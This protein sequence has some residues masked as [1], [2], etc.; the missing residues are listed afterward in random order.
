MKKIYTLLLLMIFS[1]GVKAQIIDYF[2]FE[3][4]MGDTIWI[5]FANGADTIVETLSVVANVFPAEPNESDSVLQFIVKDDSDPWVG[6]YTDQVEPMIFTEE[7]HT[8]SMMVYKEKISPL[9]MKFE[10]SLT[11]GEDVSTTVEN[12]LVDEWE[13]LNF[14]MSAAIPHYYG[15]LTIFP[16]FPEARDGGTTVLI[17]NIGSYELNTAVF[18][19]ENGLSLEIYPNP[20]LDKMAVQY[21]E[22]TGISVTDLQGKTIKSITFQKTDSKVVELYDLPSGAYIVTAETDS[23]NYSGTI[24]KK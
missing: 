3:E 2:D 10:L 1:L 24:I 7:A 22:M 13:L 19:Q 18:E 5:P 4:G 11:G 20:V 17:D 6:M 14:D 9:R 15:R 12:T 16:D 21:P 23:G 8:T